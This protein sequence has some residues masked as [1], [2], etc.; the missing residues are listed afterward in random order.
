MATPYIVTLQPGDVLYVPRHW[1][2]QVYRNEFSI[3][4]N[5]W[6]EHPEDIR[7]RLGESIV[8]LQVAQMIKGLDKEVRDLVLN[9][10][11]DDL[12]EECM[13]NLLEVYNHVI[14]E[15]KQGADR[16]YTKLTTK[17]DAKILD[18]S[19]II[20]PENRSHLGCIDNT[21]L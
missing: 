19:K 11:E 5:T 20:L 12:A 17:G 9:P 3:S 4:V 10:N 16:I 7:A 18:P 14:S 1:W 6:L 21:N 8:R 15:L 2:H 13:G